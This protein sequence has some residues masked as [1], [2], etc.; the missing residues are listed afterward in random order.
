MKSHSARALLRTA[1]IGALVLAFGL[2]GCGRK[3]G[4]DRPPTTSAVPGQ[5]EIEAQP[6]IGEDGRPVAAAKTGQKRWTP[7]DWLLD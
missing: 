3:A 6:A 5:G 4:L 1:A 7:L 2:A